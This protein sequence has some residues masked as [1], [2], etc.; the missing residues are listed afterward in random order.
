MVKD[1]AFELKEEFT[2]AS[3]VIKTDKVMALRRFVLGACVYMPGVDP[4]SAD[5][6]V[7]LCVFLN[8]GITDWGQNLRK[9]PVCCTADPYLEDTR[10]SIGGT[11]EDKRIIP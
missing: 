4:Y 6:E 8:K 11:I 1:D 2:G 3:I 9:T 5:G 10:H 7:M